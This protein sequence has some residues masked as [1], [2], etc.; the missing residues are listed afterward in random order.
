MRT[1][2]LRLFIFS[3][4]LSSVQFSSLTA[5]AKQQTQQ[6]KGSSDLDLTGYILVFNEEFNSPLSVSAYGPGTKWIAHTPYGG[7][8]GSA[9]FTNPAD[10]P[11][12]FSIENGVL[13]ITARRDT[14]GD[15]HW[16][17]GLLASIDTKANGF[18]QALGYYEARMQLPEGP[19]VWPAFWL[20]GL[21]SFKTPKTKVAEIDI[22][23]EYGV[24]S[25]IAHHHVHVWN[26]D[27]SQYSD[28][29]HSSTFQGMTTG[30]HTYG[31]LIKADYIHFYFDGVEDWKT[32]TP[33]EAKEP[34]YVLVNLALG[35]GWPI[36]KT[37]DPS[38]ML[39]QYIHVYAPPAGNSSSAT[40]P[41]TSLTNVGKR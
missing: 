22:L 17:S 28:V 10:S 16:R 1:A 7:D 30:F 4:V 31:A 32:P 12:P 33:P 34:L 8:F 2:L 40:G 3:L 36:D 29:G 9:W 23:E 37:P 20:N 35:G 14:K 11:S 21:G 18:V 19:G 25:R 15:R 26:P 27:G 6:T 5:Q 38:H 39:V 13:K 41:N 24:D